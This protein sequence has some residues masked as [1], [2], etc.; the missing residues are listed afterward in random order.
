MMRDKCPQE[1]EKLPYAMWDHR[2]CSRPLRPK[3]LNTP[4]SGHVP[5]CAV[6]VS[7]IILLVHEIVVRCTALTFQLALL[8]VQYNASVVLSSPFHARSLTYLRETARQPKTRSLFLPHIT[9]LLF[10]HLKPV[11][12][13]WVSGEI[14]HSPCWTIAAPRTRAPGQRPS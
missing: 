6:F 13:S 9:I 10:F 11:T 14:G 2:I 1:P 7:F 3:K 8:R 5:F 12:L 4:E